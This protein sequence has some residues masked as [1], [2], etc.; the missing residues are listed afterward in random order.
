MNAA[1]R[2]DRI[3]P[4]VGL[5]FHDSYPANIHAID[6]A[7]GW[8]RPDGSVEMPTVL[9]V[10]RPD[11][12]ADNHAIEVHVPPH[13]HVGHLS[14]EHAAILAPLLDDGL[15]VTAEVAQVRIRDQHPDRPGLDVR[16]R[17]H[18]QEADQ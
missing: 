14:R 6:D 3:L 17:R 12:P 8:E 1:S 15:R 9:L 13:G 11:N 10:R 4:V 5:T 2:D 16:I 18:G 7:S